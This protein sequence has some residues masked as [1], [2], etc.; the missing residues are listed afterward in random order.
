MREDVDFLAV[1]A[2]VPIFVSE[3]VMDRAASTPDE[4]ISGEPT[5][6]S[7]EDGEE[8]DIFKDFV[9]TLDLDDLDDE[10]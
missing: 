1:R 3:T 10:E 6:D 8:L 7:D 9:D 2:D 4:E 5:E